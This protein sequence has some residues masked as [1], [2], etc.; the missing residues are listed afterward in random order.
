MLSPSPQL[1]RVAVWT[2]IVLVVIMLAYCVRHSA[3]PMGIR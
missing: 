1:A 2:M 3:E